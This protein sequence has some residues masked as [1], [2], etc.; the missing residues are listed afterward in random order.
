[1]RKAI[2]YD[3]SQLHGWQKVKSVV[4]LKRSSCR[5]IWFSTDHFG[6]C[7]D[8]GMI[9]IEFETNLERLR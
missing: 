6:S 7:L 3:W 2:V 8:S 9:S 5:K 1:M 4:V